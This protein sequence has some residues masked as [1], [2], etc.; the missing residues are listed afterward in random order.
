MKRVLKAKENNQ[1]K[2]ISLPKKGI[3]AA[4]GSGLVQLWRKYLNKE[5]ILKGLLAFSIIL[6]LTLILSPETEPFHSEFLLRGVAFSPWMVRAGLLLISF[7]I[8]YIIYMDI[9]RYKPA[10]SEDLGKLGLLGI[11]LVGTIL[12]SKFSYFI[13]NAFADDLGIGTQ[14]IIFAIPVAS[15]AMLVALL[16]DIH[17]AIVFSFTMGLLSGIWVTSETLFPIYAFTGSIVASFSVIRCTKRSVLLRGCLFVG[18]ANLFTIIAIN[19]YN[20]T[21]FTYKA[22]LD[23]LF[24]IGNG[25]VLSMVVSGLLPLFESVFKI[26]TDIKLLELLDLNQPVLRTL[27][28]TAPGTYHHSI[29]VG[30]LSEAAA[31]AVRVN[32]LLARVSSYYHD[33]GKIKMPEYFIENQDSINRHDKLTPSMSSLIITSHVKEGVEIARAQKLPEVIID[34]IRQHHGRSLMTY[35]YQKAVDSSDPFVAPISEED[36]RYPGPKPQTRVAAIVMLA[37]AVEAASRVL[38]DPTP[39]RI[40]ALVNKIVT[41]IFVDGQLNECELTLKDLDEI[42]KSFN[43]ILSGIFHHRIDYPGLGIPLY[44][45]HKKS[46]TENQSKPA[47]DRKDHKEDPEGTHLSS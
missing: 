4:K 28:V 35:F 6:T 24:G 15:G 43:L 41:N 16:F 13:L 18:L 11:L 1:Q 44:D 26:T 45:T 25:L 31:E 39:A 33:I 27:L 29:I 10:L 21:L 34:I 36:Y 7:L 14:T 40:S 19:L 37:D 30:N 46:A 22:P 9:K 38:Q 23:F 3:Q 12:L 20:G 2:V 17:L 5:E 32:P 8:I 42:T 47:E